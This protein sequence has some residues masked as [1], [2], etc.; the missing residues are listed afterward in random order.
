M[1]AKKKTSKPETTAEAVVRRLSL[2]LQTHFS[3]DFETQNWIVRQ[4]MNVSEEEHSLRPDKQKQWRKFQEA[5]IR[6]EGA[7][8]LKILHRRYADENLKDQHLLQVNI[9]SI[10]NKIRYF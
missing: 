3:Q 10:F 6:R 1:P 4:F 7:E 2:F 9:Q 8:E 5:E